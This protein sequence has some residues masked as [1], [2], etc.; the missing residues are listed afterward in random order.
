M[1]FLNNQLKRVLGVLDSEDEALEFFFDKDFDSA[2][3]P[4]LW[5]P[6]DD[7]YHRY[8]PHELRVKAHLEEL[9][10]EYEQDEDAYQAAQAE[11]HAA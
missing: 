2:P 7:P 6:S 4:D 1:H 10:A 3:E 5:E 11:Y 9:F 8:T